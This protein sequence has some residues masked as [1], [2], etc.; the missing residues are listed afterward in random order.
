M[1]GGLRTFDEHA[2]RNARQRRRHEGGARFPVGAVLL[3]GLGFI[4]LLD[5]T[6]I[7]SIEDASGTAEKCD[8]HV[9]GQLLA[10][11]NR[12]L[13]EGQVGRTTRATQRG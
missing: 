4:L 10:N 1:V 12:T 7:I 11:K 6:D 8:A 2:I 3:I 9:H 5:T 13:W